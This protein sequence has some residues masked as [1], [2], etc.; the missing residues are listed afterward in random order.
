MPVTGHLAV[1]YAANGAS[2]S[3]AAGRRTPGSRSPARYARTVLRSRSRCRAI[4]EIDHPR[5]DNALASTSSPTES[6]SWRAPP[7]DRLGHRQHRGALA[8]F[9]GPSDPARRTAH[10]WGISVIESGEIPVILS[11]RAGQLA[12]KPGDPILHVHGPGA[13]AV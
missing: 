10:R 1:T 5:L 7:A 4:A 11:S 13:T 9:V 6:M 8:R 12:A 3:G 2:G